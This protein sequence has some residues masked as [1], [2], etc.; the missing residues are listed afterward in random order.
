[1]TVLVL[2]PLHSVE[3]CKHKRINE[4][5]HVRIESRRIVLKDIPWHY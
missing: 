5:S 3:E 1:M 2:S 4:E